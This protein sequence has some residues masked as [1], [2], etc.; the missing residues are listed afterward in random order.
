VQYDRCSFAIDVLACPGCGGRLRFIATIEDPPAVE[1]IL[2]HFGLP[3]AIP[4]AAPARPPP[5]GPELSFDF[6]S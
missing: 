1:R 2:R 5:T 4:E 3:T 6:P